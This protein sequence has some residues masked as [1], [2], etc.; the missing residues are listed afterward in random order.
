M[1]GNTLTKGMGVLAVA[2][3]A[4]QSQASLYSWQWAPGVGTLNNGG[5]TLKAIDASFDTLTNTLTWYARFDH[6]PGYPTKKTDGF[7]LVLSPGPNPKGHSGELAI[8]YFDATASAPKMTVYG[9]N[10]Q[11]ADTSWK[12][13][14]QLPNT[15]APDKIKSSLL[16]NSWIYDLKK[17]TNGDGTRTL[18]FSINAASINSHIP[19]WPGPD[20]PAEWTGAEF[21]N[22]I[23]VWFHWYSGS[24]F[25]YQDGW[26]KGLSHEKSGYLDGNNFRT[27]PEPCSVA[28]ILAGAAGLIFKRR[29]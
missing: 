9:Y 29:K 17:Q 8:F 3:A 19:L 12:D 7:H 6:V 28:A 25:Q 2:L 4:A 24:T 16:D 1:F 11:N 5:G 21:F 22:K 18:G 14:S 26:I 27:V 23:G 10:G 15:Q 13:G 20:G